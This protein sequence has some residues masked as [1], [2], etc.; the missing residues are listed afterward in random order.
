LQAKVGHCVVA[1]QCGAATRKNLC[2]HF[3][4]SA[5]WWQIPCVCMGLRLSGQVADSC[6]MNPFNL[7]CAQRVTSARG[8]GFSHT[9]FEIPL[10]TLNIFQSQLLPKNRI[11]G[12]PPPPSAPDE[13]N[14]TLLCFNC[15]RFS[16]I[17]R[18]IL[19]LVVVCL[20]APWQEPPRVP[21]EVG[22]NC[23][24][25]RDGRHLEARAT[26]TCRSSPSNGVSND[27]A[28]HM[29]EPLVEHILSTNG[30][31]A[32]HTLSPSL[33]HAFRPHATR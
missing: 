16:P 31:H 15:G 28:E 19:T 14:I 22:T 18:T 21:G 11:V 12:N 9:C 5:W 13:P 17:V 2:R 10:H 26:E 30:P 27:S 20:R 3:Q 24:K 32:E 33:G 6:G 23:E 25:I 4:G 29:N 1:I 8:E 7:S